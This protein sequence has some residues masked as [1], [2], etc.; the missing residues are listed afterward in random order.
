M[1]QRVLTKTDREARYRDHGC[2][3]GLTP[4]PGS[5]VV[6]GE[7][8]WFTGTTTSYRPIANNDDPR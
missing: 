7:C 5:R 8:G 6:C 3:V 4:T 1:T 2:V